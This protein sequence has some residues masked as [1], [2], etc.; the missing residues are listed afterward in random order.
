VRI[1]GGD[2]IRL[3]RSDLEL[4]RKHRKARD[5]ER[6]QQLGR[7]DPDWHRE[8]IDSAVR[9]GDEFAEVFHRSRLVAEQLRQQPQSASLHIHQAHLLVELGRTQEA[10]EHFLR[11]L[12]LNPCVS[13]WPV[14]PQAAER[15]EQAA[16]AGNW[17]RAV[18]SFQLAT[19]Q[20]E[21]SWVVPIN[22]LLAQT[23]AGDSSG[24]RK[25]TAD[26]A[27]RLAQEKDL[28][29]A[30]S[31]FLYALAV[32]W[33][34]Q[35]AAGPLLQYAEHDLARKCNAF[36]LQRYGAALYR[37]G[38]YD[39]AQRALSGSL[40]ADG[41][42]GDIATWFFQAMTARQRGKQAEAIRWLQRAEKWHRE[43]TFPRWQHRE[44][45]NALLREARTVVNTPPPMPL[46]P[47]R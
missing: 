25:T 40:L 46:V 23:A 12:S 35:A 8:Q 28:E 9:A 18:K 34:R 26:I 39:E 33:D 1:E 30:W 14:D 22:L 11:A 27:R 4:A 38:R 6:L 37:V 44:W 45:S 3:I 16:L 42:G 43:Q 13:I 17:S 24:A 36:T 21:V 31:L 32:P 7:F 41:T 29:T 5:L 15:G 10:I 20:P 19:H 47:T 2:R